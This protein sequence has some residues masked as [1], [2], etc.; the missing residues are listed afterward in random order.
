M[1]QLA[2]KDSKWLSVSDWEIKQPKWSRLVEVT[3]TI[4]KDAI[5]KHGL[6]EDEGLR[7]MFVCGG[8]VIDSFSI[9]KSD[10][11]SLWSRKD[12][13]RICKEGVVCMDRPDTRYKETL[14]NLNLFDYIDKSVFLFKDEICPNNISSTR[15]RQAVKEGITLK[16]C[17]PDLVSHYITS[18]SLYLS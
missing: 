11:S 13:E 3:E 7:V 16:Y 12:V 2:V 8:D 14:K 9:I 6:K 17:T 1:L 4:K 15:I 5:K 18:N 10:G